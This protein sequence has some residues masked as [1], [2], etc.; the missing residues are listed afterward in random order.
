M[1]ILKKL[2]FFPNLQHP[3]IIAIVSYLSL[4][5]VFFLSLGAQGGGR[6]CAGAIYCF[7]CYFNYWVLL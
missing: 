3:Q 4:Q 2:F 1:V 6:I 7:Y 5:I